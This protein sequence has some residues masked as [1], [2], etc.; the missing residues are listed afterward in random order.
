MTLTI[1][2]MIEACKTE[3]MSRALLLL[4]TS[5]KYAT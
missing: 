5:R 4:Y 3:I 1:I 2:V